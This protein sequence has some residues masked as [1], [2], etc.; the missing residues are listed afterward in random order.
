M[1]SLYLFFNHS[2][3]EDLLEMQQIE[4]DY[5]QLMIIKDSILIIFLLLQENLHIF[6]VLGLLFKLFYQMCHNLNLLKYYSKYWSRCLF[7][8]QMIII[9]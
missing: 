5:Y 7:R 2:L 9:L 1:N 4:L 8:D 3:W 6:L